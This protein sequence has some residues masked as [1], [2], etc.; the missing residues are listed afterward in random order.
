MAG[1]LHGILGTPGSLE[2]ISLEALLSWDL[3]CHLDQGPQLTAGFG[4]DVPTSLWQK[5]GMKLHAS[6][7]HSVHTH[8]LCFIS[9]SS[10]I[11]I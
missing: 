10:V 7:V 9:F 3:G 5:A 6:R 8:I 1:L 11:P 2:L 4:G